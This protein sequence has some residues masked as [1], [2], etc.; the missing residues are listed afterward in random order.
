MKRNAICG[1]GL[2]S[3]L[4]VWMGQTHIAYS[5][6]ITGDI[7]GTV[8]D[9]T[10]AV[11]PGA[12]VTLTQVGTGLTLRSATTDSSGDYLFAQLKPGHYRIDAS[13]E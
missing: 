8:K 5:Q 12:N 2:A 4:F 3:A 6:A 7:L 13:T 10:G 1:W 9:T 11:I